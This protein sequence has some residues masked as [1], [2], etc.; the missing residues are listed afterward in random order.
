VRLSIV[1][2]AWNEARAIAAS[3]AQARRVADEV[4]VADGGSTDGTADLARGAGARVVRAPKGRGVQL[5]L[6]ARAS[7]GDTLLFLHADAT[8]RGDARGAIE[9][10]LASAA[11]A[12]GNFRLRFVPPSPAAR[13]FGA[14][15]DLRRRWMRVYYGDSGIFV[16]RQVYLELGGFAH[17][18]L[19]ED[20][21]F[22]R[23][24]ERFG[25]TRYVTEAEVHVSSRR[26]AGSPIR[27]LALWA[28]LRGLYAA[29]IS[30]ARL[31][32]WYADLR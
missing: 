19:F 21:D 26:F 13:L 4:V 1:I 16:R 25:E 10:A 14:A 28:T 22:A 5:D 7:G 6:G 2:P 23:R 11:V 31:A 29:G 3:V 9:R 24:L 27:T 20:L 8:L 18:P 12:G 32:R 17:W 30:P 15:N